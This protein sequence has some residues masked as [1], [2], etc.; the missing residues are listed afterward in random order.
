MTD[1]IFVST[2]DGNSKVAAHSKYGDLAK[3]KS[4]VCM[5]TD[6]E[7]SEAGA[8]VTNRDTVKI[9]ADGIRQAK[10]HPLLG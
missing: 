8:H 3:D 4:L 1:S 6:C 9:G 7:H 10:V 2:V 5:S